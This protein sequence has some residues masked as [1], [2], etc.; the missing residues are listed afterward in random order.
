MI[1][2]DGTLVLRELP[3]ETRQES[4]IGWAAATG[5]RGAD[6]LQI[7]MQL[8]YILYHIIMQSLSLHAT[9]DHVA[10]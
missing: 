8:P 4:W 9:G 6:S 10:D 1:R 3:P 7:H 5:L 2:I